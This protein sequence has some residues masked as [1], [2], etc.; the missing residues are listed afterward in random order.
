[1]D[2][3]RIKNVFV[4][5]TAV[6]TFI[7]FWRASAI[8]LCDFGS[9][10]YYAGGI[11]AKA[12]GPAFPYFILAVMLFAGFLLMAY[13]ESSSLFTRGGVYVVVRETMG[14]TM[15][16][17]SVSA[18]L[19][20]F[21]LTGPISG[22]SAGLYL[23]Y[24]IEVLLPYFGINISV[25][26]RFIAVIFAVAVVIYFWFENLKGVKESSENNVRII[27]FVSFVAILLLFLS[28]FT[29]YKKGFVW[30]EFKF[31]FSD[32]S[33]GWAKYIDFL[34]PVGLI[35]ILMAFGHS[36]LA[37]SGLETLAQIFREVE[38]PKIKNL[39]KAVFIIFIFAFTFTGILTFLSAVI[40]PYDKIISKYSE[41]LLSGLAMELAIP[42]AFR[43]G[44]KIL[45][46]IS[47]LLLLVGAINTSMVG[48]NET[49]KRVAED[50]LLPDKIRELHPK[51]GTTYKIVT[52]VALAQSI[53]ILLSGGDVFLLG[54]AY[55]FGVLWSLTFEML[56][57]IVL[58][59]KKY[60]VEREW[61]FPLNITYDRYKIPVGLIIIFI[62]L[63]SVSFINLFTK[64]I[65]TISGISFSIILF[66]IFTHFEKK[67]EASM[68]LH[69][70]DVEEEKV[71]ITTENELK[72]IVS[73]LT[74]P[75]RILI[76]VRNPNNL[77]HLKKTLEE[78]DDSVV[79]LVVLYVK[80]EKDNYDKNLSYDSLDNDEKTLFR[81]VILMAEKY[82]KT[83]TPVIVFS[84]DPLY[85]IVY[86]AILGRF[87]EIRMGVSGNYGA[88]AQ[89]EKIALNWGILK[90]KNFDKKIMV[91]I[92]WENK[93]YDYTLN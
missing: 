44:L 2:K 78:I 66:W 43:I 33:L 71:N 77:V 55:A 64:N 88:E 74:K 67:D 47:A 46:V 86:F 56:S 16:K 42:Y 15:A 39:K 60:D 62:I 30:P 8:V 27:L 80:G 58:R 18:L 23:A 3:S 5:S 63:F 9:S 61:M 82:G 51:Y 89:L 1:M 69:K 68:E 28:V 79:D 87:D 20:D 19:F 57:L 53:I 59:F 37:L 65:A 35:G 22:V 32:E 31:H 73:K 17:L 10:A 84:N 38:D 14:K 26:H 91:K 29:I 4:L 6:L 13:I 93:E 52:L 11:A 54:E 40:I 90:P 72:N 70:E 12:Y 83:L 36:I 76:P 48:A 81:E 25:N 92:I 75:K 24:L 21:M 50:G 45:V 85:I 49:L 41:N 34:K 7:S